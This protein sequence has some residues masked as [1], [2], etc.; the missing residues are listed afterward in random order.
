MLHDETQDERAS[1]VERKLLD[2]ARTQL[3]HFKSPRRMVFG[4]LPKTATG[5]VQKHLLRER[6]RALLGKP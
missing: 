5:K 1:E 3:A 2:H 6:A 4:E